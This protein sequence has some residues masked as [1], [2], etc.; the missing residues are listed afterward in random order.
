VQI[1]SLLRKKL[2]QVSCVQAK[3]ARN[4]D[5]QTLQV[6]DVQLLTRV[7]QQV[8]AQQRRSEKQLHQSSADSNPLQLYLSKY[9]GKEHVFLRRG[10]LTV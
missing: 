1:E 4:G 8:T 9:D 6:R 10:N 7:L 3:R 5:K 2:R